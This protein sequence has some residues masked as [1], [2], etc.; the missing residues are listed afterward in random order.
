[1]ANEVKNLTTRALTKGLGDVRRTNNFVVFIEDIT[2]SGDPG[3]SLDLI[4][5]QAFLPKVSLQP[6]E[7]RHGND[8]K[9]FAGVASW[10]GGTLTIID[11]LSRK[12]LD[13]V[14]AW[15]ESTYDPVTGRIGRAETFGTETGYK[16]QGRITE[17]TEDGNL[18]REWTVEGMWISDLDLGEL[19]AS[20]GDLKQISLTIQI[21]PSS[22]KPSYG[23]DYPK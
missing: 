4:I 14:L 1:M 15:F 6:L 8:A 10:S 9:K 2:G 3:D 23:A 13:A 11:V 5:Q 7:L 22:L 20:R 12:E 17:Y 19:D 16:K 18:S 21:D